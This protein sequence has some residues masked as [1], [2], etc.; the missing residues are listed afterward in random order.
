MVVINAI[1]QGREKTEKKTELET[2]ECHDFGTANLEICPRILQNTIFG[3]ED[4]SKTPMVLE[5]D[6]RT[7]GCTRG[8]GF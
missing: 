7:N 8:V 1:S 4:D 2:I 3:L 5:N 6:S